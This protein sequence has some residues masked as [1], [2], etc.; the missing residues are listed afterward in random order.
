MS[1]GKE[2]DRCG[3][4]FGQQTEITHKKENGPFKEK[5]EI[6]RWAIFSARGNE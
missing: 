1:R 2:K 6:K 5:I 4:E 3:D